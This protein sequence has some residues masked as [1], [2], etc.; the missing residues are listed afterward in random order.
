M[1]NRLFVVS[2]IF[3]I[4]LSSFAENQCISG[5]PENSLL[6]DQLAAA[7]KQQG[8]THHICQKYSLY[9][10]TEAASGCVECASSAGKGNFKQQGELR[11]IGMSSS[12]LLY[13]DE[14]L[15]VAGSV[16]AHAKEIKCPEGK[17]GYYNQCVSP[18]LLKYENA[19]ISDFLSCM[20]KVRPDFPIS[21]EGIFEMLSL[22]SGFKPSY[23]STNG[24][25]IGQ[26]VSIFVKDISQ[27][28]RGRRILKEV[29]DSKDP[30]CAAAQ[31]LAFKDTQNPNHTVQLTKSN[32][33]AFTQVG[34]GMERNILYSLVGMANAWEL[35]LAPVMK[36]FN[37][38]SQKD[39]KYSTDEKFR[40]NVA[41]AQELAV[42]NSYGHGGRAAARAAARRLSRLS[43]EAFVKAI[44]KP[45]RV[46]EDDESLTSYITTMQSRQRQLVS[47][48]DEPIKSEFG[49]S[50]AKACLK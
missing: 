24:V 14:C 12:K 42:L 27:E 21:A 30:D 1:Q 8:I 29:A 13:K 40:D 43:P 7:Q 33:C 10:T 35:D 6:N 41:R 20:K 34:E 16:L 2:F 22:E 18:S 50:G 17:T 48:F 25:G 15:T 32:R 38:R 36:R 44:K 37:E 39:P 45:L 26:L 47:K 19:V 28:H 3:S 46:E 23:A 9:S 49:K 5:S 31:V 4:S 11:P